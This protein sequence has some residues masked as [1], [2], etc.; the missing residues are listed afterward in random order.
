MNQLR[1]VRAGVSGG[2]ESGYARSFRAQYEVVSS[3]ELLAIR[4]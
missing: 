4:K 2:A 3:V 1:V